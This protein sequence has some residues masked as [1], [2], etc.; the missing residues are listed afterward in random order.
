M[1]ISL[2]ETLEIKLPHFEH[3][4]IIP[5]PQKLSLPAQ[6]RT[7]QPSYLRRVGRDPNT[8]LKLLQFLCLHGA[9]FQGA[10]HQNQLL[11]LFSE[12][13]EVLEV[14]LVSN[15]GHREDCVG[16]CATLVAKT[17]RDGPLGQCSFVF[18]PPY[19]LP[20]WPHWCHCMP[21][22]SPQRLTLRDRS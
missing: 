13:S 1:D 5:H 9:G 3:C 8:A 2:R 14:E 21:K 20:F 22:I 7:H 16:R 15:T 10:I 4:A 11:V 18:P 19:W 6:A 12:T 17:T